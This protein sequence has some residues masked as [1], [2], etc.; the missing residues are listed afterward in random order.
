[1]FKFLRS[2]A[3]VFYWVIAATFILFLIL[4]GLTGRGCQAPGTRNLE[5]GVVGSVNGTKI[6]AQQYDYAVRQQIAMMRQQSPDRDLN[7]NQ[8]AMARERA[9]DALVQNALVE[10]AIKDRKIKVDDAEVLDA[11]RNNPPAE[12]LAGCPIQRSSPV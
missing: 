4:G 8:Y 11:F 10:Q 3:K 12:L 2:Q 1:M 7:A 6:S 5:A 9:W